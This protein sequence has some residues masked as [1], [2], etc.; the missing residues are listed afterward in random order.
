MWT[1]RLRGRIIG[2]LYAPHLR[3]GMKV[4]DLG[5]GNGTV[6]R[7]LRDR[8]ELDLTC[9]DIEDY[10][11][12]DVP[13]VPMEDGR[14]PFPDG[15][16][17]AAML[18]D[19]LHHAVDQRPLIEEAVRIGGIVLIFEAE[20][21]G[22]FALFDRIINFFHHRG[23]P[24]PL[25]FRSSDEWRG[26]LAAWGFRAVVRPLGRPRWWYPFRHILIIIER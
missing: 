20:P 14:L 2:D 19:V 9:T 13:F 8:F 3:S 11:R 18:N 7:Q 25:A 12:T 17:D 15:R 1:T 16:F 22:P 5:C 26:V 23:M 21:G 10:R 6:S 24:V 4:I